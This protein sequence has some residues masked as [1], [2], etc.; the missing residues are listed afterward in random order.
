MALV[1]DPRNLKA[2]VEKLC[3]ATKMRPRYVEFPNVDDTIQFVMFAERIED[4]IVVDVNFDEGFRN[5]KAVDV[6]QKTGHE[7]D[8]DF[9]EIATYHISF[10][11]DKEYEDLAAEINDIV[12]MTICP[13]ERRFRYA[14]EEVCL[15]CILTH[16][17][18]HE[19]APREFCCVCQKTTIDAG[20]TKFPCCQNFAH[21]GCA[22]PLETCPYCRAPAQNSPVVVVE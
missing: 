6:L 21:K 14:D 13:C 2:V 11:A 20:M 19:E 5:K 18:F 17:T 15:L 1:H 16:T 4:G 10:D 12:G 9:F 22:K 3:A 7:V 8:D